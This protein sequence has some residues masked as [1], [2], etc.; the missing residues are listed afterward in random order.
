MSKQTLKNFVPTRDWILV[1][2]PRKDETEGGIILPEG[3]SAKV[4]SNISEIL[5]IGPDCKQAKIGDLAMI[6]PT[7]TGSIIDIEEKTY[8]MV[9]EHFCLG[10]FEQK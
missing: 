9:P 8:I 1:A 10:I 5:S 7:T 2:D 3:V 4:Q 6:N